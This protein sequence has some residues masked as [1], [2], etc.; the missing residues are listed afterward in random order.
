MKIIT[1]TLLILGA[2]AA[3]KRNAWTNPVSSCDGAD[4]NVISKSISSFSPSCR[5]QYIYPT[6]GV[7]YGVTFVYKCS[8][9]LHGMNVSHFITF[10]SGVQQY[11]I[12]PKD[13]NGN[14]I[15]LKPYKKF[16][17]VSKD[18][19]E[20]LEISKSHVIRKRDVTCADITKVLTKAHELSPRPA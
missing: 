19:P 1:V 16:Y 2:L 17:D 7:F 15:T 9:S 11:G 5:L 12:R 20:I 14:P 4:N 6:I 10:T 3:S 13:E 8:Q 18:E